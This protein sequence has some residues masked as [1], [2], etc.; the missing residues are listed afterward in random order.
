MRMIMMYWAAGTRW[1]AH[2]YQMRSWSGEVVYSHN[3]FWE[4]AGWNQRSWSDSWANS[5]EISHSWGRRGTWSISG[6]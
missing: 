4:D 3:G 2:L 6:Y 5:I 1:P